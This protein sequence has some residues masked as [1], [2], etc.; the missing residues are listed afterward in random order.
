MAA[1][2]SSQSGNFN[3][4]STWGGSAVPVDNDTFT[5]A[6]GHIVT[7]NDDRRTTNGYGNSVI[8]GKLHI[9][10]TGKL[11]MYGQLD[12]TSTGSSGYFTENDSTT[13]AFLKMDNGARLEFKGNNSENHSLRFN[14]Q[15]YNWIEVSGTNPNQ[16]TTISSALAINST[17]FTVASGTGFAVG[18]WIAIQRPVEDMTDWAGLNGHFNDE[19]MIVHDISGTTIYPR[20]Y[21]SPN[22]DITKVSGSKIFVGNASAFRVDQKIIFGTGSNRNVKTISAINKNTNTITC[23]SSISGSVVGETVYR[24]GTEVYHHANS[25]VTKI[26]TSLTANAS[27]GQSVITVGSTAGMSAGK[28]IVIE[29]NNDAETNWDYE[30]VYTISSISGNNV[31]LTSN[32]SNQRLEGA[33]VALFDRDTYIGAATVQTDSLATTSEDR[34]YIYHTRWTSSDAYYR[35]VRYQNVL[36]EGMGSNTTNSSWYRGV[37]VAGYMSFDATSYGQYTSIIE[38]CVWRP[39]NRSNNASIGSRDFHQGIFRNNI[40]VNGVHN[41]W[42]WGG[43]NSQNWNNNI[44]WRS[45]YVTMLHEGSWEPRTQFHYNHLSRSDDYGLL[46]YHHANSASII[47]HNY[48]THH[49]NRPIYLY[50]NTPNAVIQNCYIDAYRYWP[51]LGSRGGDLIYQDC[52]LGNKWDFSGDST[53][54]DEFYYSGDG[55][56]RSDRSEPNLNYSLNHNWVQNA[57]V[58]WGAHQ[59]R[60]WDDDEAAWE[61][62]QDGATTATSGQTESM[63]VPAGSTVYLACEVKVNTGFSGNFPYIY[64]RQANAAYDNG[65]AYNGTASDNITSSTDAPSY[66]YGFRETS[67]R[68][69]TADINSWVRKTLTVSSQPYD[70]ILHYGVISDSVNAG[71]TPTEFWYQKPMEAYIDKPSGLVEKRFSSKAQTKAGQGANANVKKKRFG[72]R[73]K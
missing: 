53:A 26:A 15:K 52:W 23:D 27:S 50:Y 62:H 1:R 2:T 10:G 43:G 35:R 28:R 21:V 39:N 56:Q 20:W 24:T 54:H 7:V 40:A 58:I 25:T 70:Y 3:S 38:G 42:K 66:Y 41:F 48:F 29:A 45:Q 64:A 17:S 22:S 32:L 34:P 5:I 46:M 69:E 37:M 9:T 13:G 59:W 19:G 57:T 36:F 71:D 14:S 12:I 61:V 4:T 51:Y 18:D 73:L 55:N 11:R 49:E 44:S 60:K 31:T 68:W 30:N 65:G 72:G 63:F 47:R 67:T 6:A 33:W 8:N 16:S